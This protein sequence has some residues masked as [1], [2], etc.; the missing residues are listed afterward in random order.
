MAFDR[1]KCYNGED[2]PD[3][4]AAIAQH[5]DLPEEAQKKA[6]RATGTDMDE[7]HKKFLAELIGLL[8]R[9]EIDP[10]T[11]ATLLKQENY[12][13]LSEADRGQV[14]FALFNLADQ[15]RVVEEYFR[16]KATPNA[17]PELQTMIEHLW[18]MVRRLEEKH[19]DVLKL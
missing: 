17:S 13:K 16:S 1:Q 19:G 7:E 18:D 2:M 8:D 12:G 15:V 9:K 4:A 10:F 11:P 14:D 3:F 6:G 5:Q